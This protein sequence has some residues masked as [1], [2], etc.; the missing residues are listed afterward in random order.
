VAADIFHSGPV[1]L[2]GDS[3]SGGVVDPASGGC[4]KDGWKNGF[5]L[6]EAQNFQALLYHDYLLYL[7]HSNNRLPAQS[8]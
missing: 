5:Q 3:Y 1:L 2:W 8:K 6:K 4:L 7:F